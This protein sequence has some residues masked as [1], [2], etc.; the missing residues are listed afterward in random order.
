MTIR[1][2]YVNKDIITNK[3]KQ[4]KNEWLLCWTRNLINFRNFGAIL[5]YKLATHK[6]DW[7]VKAGIR[8][9]LELC[10]G[11]TGHPCF[12]FFNQLIDTSAVTV[13]LSL[14]T[15]R[16]VWIPATNLRA[17]R[18]DGISVPRG[19]WHRVVIRASWRVSYRPSAGLILRYQAVL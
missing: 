7:N 9:L 4:T 1:K 3:T 19:S 16:M 11:G 6:A 15:D 18:W 12:S 5:I 10:K 14:T 8:A 2:L 17:Q 13:A